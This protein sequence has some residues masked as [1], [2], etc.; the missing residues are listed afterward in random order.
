MKK[1]TALFLAALLLSVSL[2]SCI[3]ASRKRIR[4]L[5]AQTILTVKFPKTTYLFRKF[6]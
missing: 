2:K 1:T 6:Q 3:P 5:F 4:P